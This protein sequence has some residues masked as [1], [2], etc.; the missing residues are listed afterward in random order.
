LPR[1]FQTS[2]GL[3]DACLLIKKLGKEFRQLTLDPAPTLLTLAQLRK[4]Q[5]GVPVGNLK[6]IVCIS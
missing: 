3:L 1:G 6:M 5:K 2:F 4:M